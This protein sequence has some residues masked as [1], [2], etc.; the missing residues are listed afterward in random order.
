MVWA[1]S[2][3]VTLL[4][5]G[6]LNLNNNNETIGS[7]AAASAAANVQLGSATLTTTL[8]ARKA[9]LASMMEEEQKALPLK[10]GAVKVELKPFEI[11]TVKFGI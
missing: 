1:T 5:D 11:V 2:A 4:A 7:L 6:R 3:A 10:D 8:P 9:W